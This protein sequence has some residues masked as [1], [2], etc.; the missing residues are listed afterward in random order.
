MPDIANHEKQT[1]LGDIRRGVDRRAAP[2]A[3]SVH[4]AARRRGAGLTMAPPTSVAAMAGGPDGRRT[5]QDRR[6]HL[7]GGFNIVMQ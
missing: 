4:P 7:H 2:R 6:F 5:D 1:L 3:A